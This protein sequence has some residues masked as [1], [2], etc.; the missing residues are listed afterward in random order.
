MGKLRLIKKG[1]ALWPSLP[2]DEDKLRKW[3]DGRI[4]ECELRAPRNAEHHRKFFA[5]LRV[6]IEH[7]G[8]YQNE[9][10]LLD[11]VKIAVGHVDTVIGFDGKPHYIPK[12][13]SWA[14]MDQMAFQDFYDQ[15]VDAVLEIMLPE[16]DRGIMDHAV[17]EIL[18]FM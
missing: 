10:I 5:M 11:V 14:S 17:D 2:S 1:D 16:W 8:R 12:S 13:I 3:A 18:Q 6:A 15:A 4:I 7:S 9:D